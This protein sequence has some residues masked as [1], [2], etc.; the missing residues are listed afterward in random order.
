MNVNR[1]LELACAAALLV[2]LA[3]PVS[4]APDERLPGWNLH[5]TEGRNK[6]VSR[7]RAAAEDAQAQ[8][9]LRAAIE[10]WSPAGDGYELQAFRNNRPY[11]YHTLNS[12]AAISTVADQ[13]RD[14]PPYR[15]NGGG[16]TVGVWDGGAVRSS[17]QELTNRV[18]VMDGAAVINHATHVGGTIGASGVV[19]TARGMAPGVRIDSY[20]WNSDLAEMASR[21]MSTPGEAGTIQLSN[22]S[23]GF[24]TGW[25]NGSGWVWYGI[26]G[27]AKDRNFGR[28]LETASDLDLLC[29][30]APYYLPCRAAGNDRDD[31]PPPMGTSFYYYDNGWLTKNYNPATDPA[32]DGAYFGGY[33]TV[34]GDAVAK[35]ILTV[36]AVYDAVANGARSLTNATMSSFS[37][38]GP[39]DDGRIK[40]DVVGNG[41]YLYSSWGTADNAYA[42]ASGTSMA[43]PNVCGSA[44]LLTDWYGTLFPG[45]YLRAST[46]KGL[47]IHTADDLG[48]P[49][50]DYCFGWG[51]MNTK[52]AADLLQLHR[53]AP[54][55]L[56]LMECAL[57]TFTTCRTNVF[58]WD[59]ASAIRATLCWTDP[60][61][62]VPE[63]LDNPAR[64]LVNDLDLR[65]VD[66]SGQAYYPY[67]LSR[68]NPAAFATTGT[69]DCDNVEQVYI[70]TPGTTG[71]YRVIVSLRG[72]LTGDTQAYSLLLSGSAANTAQPP[73]VASTTPLPSAMVAQAYS[74]VLTAVGASTGCVWSLVAGSL[75]PGVALEPDGV[76]HGTPSTPTNAAFRVRVTE[77]NGLFAEA[78]FSLAA[79]AVLFAEGFENGGAMPAGWTQQYAAGSV[80]WLFQAGG[81]YDGDTTS[82][83]P[84]AA[85]GGSYNAFLYVGAYG[86]YRTR[87]VT[88][89]IEF[90]AATQQAQLRFWHAQELWGPDQDELRVYRSDA[91]N[92]PWTLLGAYTNSTA[93]WTPR[94]LAL[95]DPAACYFAFEGRVKW[96]YGVCI[97]DVSVTATVPSGTLRGTPCQWLEQQGLVTGGNYE[98]ADTGDT[99]GDGFAAWQEY[100]AGTVPTN[101]ASCFRADIAVSNG[102]PRVGWTPDLGGG[103]TYTVEGRTELAAGAWGA[104]NADSRFFRVKVSLP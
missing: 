97:D 23:Y 20:D 17:H 28:Y 44:A 77:T 16:R 22:H 48:N 93:A 103:R 11:I 31:G 85:H 27:E 63:G 43:T 76:L 98:A 59:G 66:P 2:C 24:L 68:T 75:P 50:P 36:G 21:A 6:V 54:S 57:D 96:G 95:P 18:T 10:G 58:T 12:N 56:H 88:P 53:D 34:G 91:T 5:A 38:W 82:S 101:G 46:L 45:Q 39:A 70:A 40:P 81:L 71:E 87:L 74:N 72:S 52:A 60:P 89:R 86:D 73:V 37:G 64:A 78:T 100:V 90:G 8:A 62:A 51:L 3:R 83:H 47:I 80:D 14:T 42:T 4:A 41:M 32:G 55:A 29:Y 9:W 35:N 7:L 33:D 84:T 65:I 30:Y 69:N 61:G 25:D 19:A 99:D 102:Q 67:V 49:G 104:T 13:V 15:V 94:A 92:G 1:R 79:D 26:W